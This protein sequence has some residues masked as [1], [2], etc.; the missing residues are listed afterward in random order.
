MTVQAQDTTETG[1]IIEGAYENDRN[2]KN[3]DLF[4]SII[5]KVYG[6][7]DVIIGH[8]L[9]Y[10]V[11]DKHSDG[12]VYQVVEEIPS[13]DT[14]IFDHK[15]AQVLFGARY[16]DCLSQLAREP[17]ETRDALLSKLINA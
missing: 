11:E 2:A 14:L 13:A 15:V 16:L 12:F 17:V 9:V 5:R 7:Q 6:V 3:R 8:H 1:L 10:Q 4:K